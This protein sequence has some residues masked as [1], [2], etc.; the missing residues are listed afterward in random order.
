VSRIGSSTLCIV[1]EGNGKQMQMWS[2][3]NKSEISQCHAMND[4]IEHD[5][6]GEV[7]VCEGWFQTIVYAKNT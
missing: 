7:T 5:I 1:H 4:L 2:Y 6:I 3:S